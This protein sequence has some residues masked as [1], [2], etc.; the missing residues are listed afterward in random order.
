MPAFHGQLS[1]QQIANVAAFV[2]SV[3]RP[4]GTAPRNA[5]P[6]RGRGGNRRSHVSCRLGKFKGEPA[7]RIL[8]EDRPRS[9]RPE[10]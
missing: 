1:E 6:A 10:G 4:E 8:Q 3:R 2:S 9:Y 5:K 7:R